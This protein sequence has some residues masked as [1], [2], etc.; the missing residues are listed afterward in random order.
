MYKYVLYINIYAVHIL[1][2][3]HLWTQSYERVVETENFFKRNPT[4]ISESTYI[5]SNTM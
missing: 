4:E 3:T 2:C 1:L 5:L